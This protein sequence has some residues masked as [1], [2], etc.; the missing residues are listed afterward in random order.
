MEN[1]K[2]FRQTHIESERFQVDA[3]TDRVQFNINALYVPMNE[4]GELSGGMD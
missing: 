2:H 3:T 4:T 1:S